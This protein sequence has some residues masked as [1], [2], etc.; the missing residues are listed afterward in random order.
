MNRVA[1]VYS[2]HDL[3]SKHTG[4]AGNQPEN[5]KRLVQTA[6]KTIFTKDQFIQVKEPETNFELAKL[7][8]DDGFLD[9]LENGWQRWCEEYAQVPNDH[10]WV[11][12]LHD[13]ISE[14]EKTGKPGSVVPPFVPAYAAPRHDGLQKP[15]RGILGQACFYGLDRETPLVSSTSSSLKWDMA[16]I[17]KA[18]DTLL[19]GSTTATTGT[20]GAEPPAPTIPRIVYAQ[21]THPGHHASRSAY[22]GFCFINQAAIAVR[23]LQTSGRFQRVAVIDVDY[24]H[25]N[26]TMSIFWNDPTVFFASLHGDPHQDYPF[27]CGFPDQVSI[28]LCEQI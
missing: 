21:I 10:L 3:E 6:L 23:L 19:H 2:A 4:V 15:S 1:I 24:H 25:G 14:E 26:G 22:G 5:R 27:N 11:Y 8:H 9:F 17:R 28:C 18:V 16:V 7:V 20:Q 12:G 13:K